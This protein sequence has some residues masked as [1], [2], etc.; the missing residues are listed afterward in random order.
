MINGP[1]MTIE[2]HHLEALRA[3]AYC[4]ENGRYH[5]G[6]WEI[7]IDVP[8][9]AERNAAKVILSLYEEQEG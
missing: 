1:E 3:V 9:E 2:I 7:V 4:D 8:T 5:G 6:D